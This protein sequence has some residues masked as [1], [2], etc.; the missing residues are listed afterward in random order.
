VQILIDF[1]QFLEPYGF[2][3]HFVIFGVLLACGFGLPM[4]E[5]I[6]LVSSGILASRGLSE[7]WLMTTICLIGVIV[8]DKIIFFL[9]R[10]YGVSLKQS[11]LLRHIF[12]KRNDESI[13][14]LF[15]K[16]GHRIIFLGRFMPGLRAPIFFTSGVYQVSPSRF[17]ALD[18]GAALLSVPAWIGIGYL[19]GQNLEMLE[20]R[21]HQLHGAILIGLTVVI[22]LSIG[23]SVVRRVRKAN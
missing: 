11:R 21:S 12:S 6:V 2:Y 14:A 16:H 9:G 4:P 20:A 8:G 19:F 1:L 22:G 18:G 13:K 17:L 23:I 10:R 5:D 7:F 15:G 3:S